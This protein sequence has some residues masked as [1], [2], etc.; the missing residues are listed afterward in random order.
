MNS[1][2]LS[3]LMPNTATELIEVAE[4]LDAHRAFVER[5]GCVWPS[6]DEID[7]A[8]ITSTL[9]EVRHSRRPAGRSR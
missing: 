5:C 3:P 9:E 6:L 7:P 8:L 1:L 4:L 2:N